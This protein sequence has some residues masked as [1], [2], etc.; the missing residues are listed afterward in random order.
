[1][2]GVQLENTKDAGGGLNVGW[3][4]AGDWMDYAVNVAAAGTYKVELSVASQV[5]TGSIQLKAGDAVLSTIAVPNTGGWQTWKTVS[6]EASL[7]AGQ[8]T[9]RVHAAGP[10]FN[11]NWLQFTNS[12]PAIGQPATQQP[13]N[14]LQNPGFETGNLTGWTEW[15]GGAESACKADRQTAHGRL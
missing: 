6:G 4:E 13:A 8:Q 1:M 3:I 10:G 7:G 5:D 11:L 15:H 12:Q 9:L 14:L 2:S